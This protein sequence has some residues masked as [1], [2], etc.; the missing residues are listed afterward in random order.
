MKEGIWKTFSNLRVGE[1]IIVP[2]WCTNEWV[3]SGNWTEK[4]F[5]AILYDVNKDRLNE[6]WLDAP[7]SI[8]QDEEEKG[9]IEPA[10]FAVGTVGPSVDKNVSKWLYCSVVN[11]TCA[12][13]TAA[14][15]SLCGTSVIVSFCLGGYPWIL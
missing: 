8:I 2:I 14:I 1:N 11:G 10:K 4:N 13:G 9:R 7:E 3:P 15:T 6:M 5:G 12:G